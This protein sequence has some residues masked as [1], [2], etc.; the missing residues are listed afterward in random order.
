MSARESAVTRWLRTA[1]PFL[2]ALYGGLA[3]FAAYSAMYAFRKPFTAASFEH[4]AGWPF[5]IDFKVALVIA[6]VAG[7]AMSK[8]IG[9]KI[10]SEMPPARRAAG[11]LTLIGVAELA[12]I[13]FATLPAVAG[14]AALFL[15]GLMLGMIWGLVFGFLEGRRL[16]EVLG[17]MLCASFILSSGL[18]KSAGEALILAGW[19]SERWMPAATG[20][21]FTPL[22]LVSVWALA[23]LPPPDSRDEAE[24]APRVP[25]GREQRARLFA[26]YAPS[27]TALIG[28]YVMLTALRDF[29]DNFAAEIWR[30]LGFAG[31]AGIFTVS[32]LPVAVVVLVSMG[33]L[34]RVRDNR[35]AV[36]WNLALIALGFALLGLA[37]AAF[38]LGLIGAVAWMIV[39]GAGL[40]FAYTPFNAL[41]FD[42]LM[43]TAS[44]PGNA[45]FL[46]YVADAC[47]YVGSVALLLFRSFAHVSL[48]W[49]NFL[50]AVCYAAC[51][52]G[53][54]G[55]AFGAAAFRHTTQAPER[56]LTLQPAS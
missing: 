15:N 23:Q 43:A 31:E 32:E 25:M 14:I 55:T 52:L 53:L 39:I 13:G 35:A 2:F 21:A 22:L 37:T 12:L 1:P 3:G 51:G 20:L 19:A 49:S 30:E 41:L 4:V 6:Q 26:A 47:G 45:G 16:S 36:F 42:R 56:A 50:C 18:V 17:A 40:Y 54:A 38:Q 48:D 27:L 33:M 10:V 46:I 11:I 5:A 29:R 44:V 34:I 7:Y 24:R 9:I 28:V 8:V